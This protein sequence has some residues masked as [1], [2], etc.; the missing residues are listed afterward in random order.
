MK[1][2]NVLIKVLNSFYP[3][4]QF[5]ADNGNGV[6]PK[7]V[8]GIVGEVS[9][10]TIGTMRKELRSS[11]G[12]FFHAQPKEYMLNVGVQGERTSNAHDIA[13]EIQFLL[14]TMKYKSELR[15]LGYSVR[16]DHSP[17][18]NLPIRLDTNVFIRYQFTVFL[19]TDISMYIENDV[20]DSVEIDKGRIESTGGYVVEEYYEKIEGED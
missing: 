14:N 17:L 2:D 10:K 18:K 8:F 12:K 19:T 6:H 7:S 13:E 9:S 11:N 15:R 20:I 3:D 4:I 5:I 1:P 16:V